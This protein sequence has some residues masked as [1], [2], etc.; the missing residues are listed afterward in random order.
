[1][2]AVPVEVEEV[3]DLPQPNPV[4]RIAQSSAQ[5]ARDPQQAGAKCLLQVGTEQAVI[6]DLDYLQSLLEQQFDQAA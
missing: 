3:G 5:D 6:P 4:E 2:V 1:M